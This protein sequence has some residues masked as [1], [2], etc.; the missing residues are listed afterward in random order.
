MGNTV[1]LYDKEELYIKNNKDIEIL[2]LTHNKILRCLL[3]TDCYNLKEIKFNNN[4]ESEIKIKYC[5]NLLSVSN[6]FNDY[7]CKSFILGN[8]CDNITS[9]ILSNFDSINVNRSNLSNIKEII[10][11]NIDDLQIDFTNCNSLEYLDLSFIRASIV[12]LTSDNLR[13]ISL[14]NCNINSTILYEN[15]DIDIFRY[16]N[17]SGDLL[18]K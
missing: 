11:K 4:I 7:F 13:Y 5:P 17:N 2:D 6:K 1:N 3:V 8:Q 16:F 15:K 10:F 14:L 18:I 12:D 9:L